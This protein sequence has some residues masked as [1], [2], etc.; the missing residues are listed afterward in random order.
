[1]AALA[2]QKE[3]GNA[4][5]QAVEAL[6]RGLGDRLV[7]AVLFGSR[8]RGDAQA[9]SDWDLLVIARDLPDRPFDRQ[10][11]LN[12]LVLGTADAVSV[13]AKTPEE[14]ESHLPSLY[15]DIATDGQVIYDP[16]GYAAARLQTLRFIIRR[17]GLYRKRT[18]AGDVWRW[19]RRPTHPWK[20]E[21]SA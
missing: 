10:L 15:L 21:W 12:E 2:V 16:T 13:L 6:H 8:A 18:P 20:L 4:T 14:F 9:E 5:A 3:M 11:A 1:M 17:Q 19:R 7:A